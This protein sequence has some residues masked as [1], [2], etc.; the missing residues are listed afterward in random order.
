MI[1]KVMHLTCYVC[2]NP[3]GAAWRRQTGSPYTPGTRGATSRNTYS[4]GVQQY[5]VVDLSISLTR[6]SQALEQPV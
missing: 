4:N 6:L 5:P 1:Y 2:T 3:L